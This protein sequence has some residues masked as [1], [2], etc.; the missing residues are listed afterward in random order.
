ME[1]K[2]NILKSSSLFFSCCFIL[3]GQL[4]FSQNSWKLINQSLN[5][6]VPAPLA[7]ENYFELLDSKASFLFSTSKN[8]SFEILLPN[9]N[10]KEE[11]FLL[12]PV[13]LLSPSLSKKYISIKTFKGKSVKRPNVKVRMST[14]PNG[15]N[16]WIQLEG[17]EDLFIQPVKGKKKVHFVYKK[18]KNDK[19]LDFYCKTI[20]KTNQTKGERITQKSTPVF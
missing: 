9:E 4:L 6:R 20:H 19:A 14:H 16:A 12:K 1:R 10:G 2:T 5:S 15:I 7:K 13:A 18:I 17:K 3:L 8:D 11:L